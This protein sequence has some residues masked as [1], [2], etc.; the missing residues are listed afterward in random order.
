MAADVRLPSCPR[1]RSSRP[2]TAGCSAID[3][4]MDAD[5]W[6]RPRSAPPFGSPT[7]PPRRCRP[8]RRT[9]SSSAPKRILAPMITR[10]HEGARPP[11][12][13]PSRPDLSWTTVAALYRDGLNPDWNLLYPNRSSG[14]APAQRLL[15]QHRQPVLDRGTRRPG[16]R[17]R[18]GHR[19]PSSRDRVN[20]G[21]DDGQ[22]HRAVPRTGRRARRIRSRAACRRVRRPTGLRRHRRRR[23]RRSP[24]SCALRSRASADSRRERCA[25][26]QTIAGDL[27]FDSIMVADLFSGLRPQAPRRDYRPGGVQPGHDDRRRDRAWRAGRYASAADGAAPEAPARATRCAGPSPRSSGSASSEE[28][29]ALADRFA[30]GEAIG[31]DNPYFLVN[32]GVTRDTSIINGA[33]VINFSSYNYLG[34][35]ATRRSPRRC[36]MRCPLRQLR[37]R[38]AACSPVRS[39]CTSELEAELAELLGTEDA[40]ALVSGHAT[41]V[42]VIGHLR[43][44]RRPGDPRQPRPQ[45]HHAG[46]QA[47][48]RHPPAVP[49]QRRTPRSTSCSPTTRHQYRRV[50]IIIE[51]VYSQDGDIPDLPA[52]IEVKQRHQALL[53]IDEAHSLGVLGATGGGIGEHFG[54]DRADVELWSGTLSKS[55]ASCGGYVAGSRELIQFLKY[56]TP[57]FIFSAGMPPANAAAALAAMRRC[58][59]SPS[60]LRRPAAQRPHCSWSWRK[61]PAS[62]RATATARRSSRASSATRPTTLRLSTRCC[63]AASTPTRS[64]TRRCPRSWPDCGS[65]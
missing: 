39:P 38:R 57:G 58:A 52:L 51:G 19:P 5:Y 35:R 31:V 24:R 15:V 11:C 55:L 32:D 28:V 7:R 9:S 26:R 17:R 2:C 10:S 49:A 22:S 63:G 59:P 16:R 21:F 23:R 48:R 61:K 12:P 43:R 42:T 50:L 13:G 25:P 4:P 33:E 64:S 20:E 53:M 56:T 27:G 30:F 3:E 65:S 29:K 6:D 34:C 54:V 45:Q 37:A 1:S 46:L 8:N 14:A 60:A 18:R 44:R 47:L 62:T 40:I 41:N 36:R